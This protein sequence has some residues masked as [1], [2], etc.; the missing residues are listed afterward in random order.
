M[1]AIVL[2]AQLAVLAV[3]VS[4]PEAQTTRPAPFAAAPRFAV[5]AEIGGLQ[6][7]R[8][9]LP[10]AFDFSGRIAADVVTTNMIGWL[11]QDGFHHLAAR[12]GGRDFVAA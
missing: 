12:R 11:D 1:K 2:F 9:R 5:R 4:A 6:Y 8:E 7:G 3:A 10:V